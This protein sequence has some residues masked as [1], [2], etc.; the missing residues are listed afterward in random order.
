MTLDMFS[1][2][3]FTFSKVTHW[4]LSALESSVFD[5]SEN[6]TPNYCNPIAYYGPRLALQIHG[7]AHRITTCRL[8][9]HPLR[10][11]QCH[12]P[13]PKGSRSPQKLAWTAAPVFKTAPPSEKSA[14]SRHQ[15]KY[16][17][18]PCQSSTT[19]IDSTTQAFPPF[20]QSRASLATSPRISTSCRTS[21]STTCSTPAAREHQ[22]RPTASSRTRIHSVIDR[23]PNLRTLTLHLLTDFREQTSPSRLFPADSRRPRCSFRDWRLELRDPT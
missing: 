14:S 9:L 21:A 22:R 19:R 13:L 8:Q 3:C 20:P 17:P 16:T 1:N 15:N 23:C 18:K 12:T 6:G 4:R 7:P 11:P 5:N 10:S 2:V